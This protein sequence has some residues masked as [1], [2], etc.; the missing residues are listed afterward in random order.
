LFWL[1]PRN[2]AGGPRWSK[3]AIE[4]VQDYLNKKNEE[5]MI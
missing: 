2:Q 5:E 1:P 4:I 3:T